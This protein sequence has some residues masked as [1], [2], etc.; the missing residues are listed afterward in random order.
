MRREF[1]PEGISIPAQRRAT[2]AKAHEM[3]VEL[4]AEFKNAG[5]SGRSV[6]KRPEFQRML[7]FI[8]ERGDGEYV[9]VDSL[10]RANR[11]RFDDA[12]MMMQLRGA[13]VRVVSAT[14][15]IDD[16]PAGQLLHGILAAVNEFRSAA[17]GRETSRKLVAKAT[18]GGTP[19]RA[20]IGYLNVHENHDGHHVA[21][22]AIDPDRAPLVRLGFE[23]MASGE[24]TLETVHQMLVDA[25]LMA[26]PHGKRPVRPIARSKVATMLRDRYY[27]G[28]V[29]F[30]GVE[31][32]GR[33]E[34]LITPELFHRVQKVLDS[35]SG[36]GTR[37][38]RHHHYLKGSLYCA[39]CGNRLIIS[40]AKGI[41]EYWLCRGRQPRI[42]DL[43]YL[44]VGHVEKAV[45]AHW[46]TLVFPQD[47]RTRVEE[48]LDRELA[49]STHTLES[50]R[51][52]LEQRLENSP[53][54][55]ITT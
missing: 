49:D 33:H 30:K 34:P 42:C 12:M 51:T 46:A 15:S 27:L 44:A 7:A 53:P 39:R 52:A 38:R 2:Q 54:R 1:D 18:I 3:G 29:T 50:H 16:T 32:Q 37:N 8:R 45:T 55:K 23:L 17:D 4:V 28:Y 36:A 31:Y 21:T 24:H 40:I 47:F 5:I 13:G 6:D 14:E 26:L 10:S 25:G 35:H 41:Y 43:P 48:I 11:N 19:G 9:I 22:V 20:K